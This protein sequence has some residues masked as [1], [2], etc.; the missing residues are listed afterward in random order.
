MVR[1][2]GKNFL[3]MKIPIQTLMQGGKDRF[4]SKDLSGRCDETGGYHYRISH[5]ACMETVKKG[6]YQQ[7]FLQFLQFLQFFQNFRQPGL[8]VGLLPEHAPVG[9]LSATYAKTQVGQTTFQQV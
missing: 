7:L 5:F 6:I 2:E 8:P 4:F 1:D 3:R 9:I